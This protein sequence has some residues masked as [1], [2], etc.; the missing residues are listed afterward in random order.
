M[1]RINRVFTGVLVILFIETLAVAFIY[2]TFYEAFIIGLP[3]LLVPFWLMK[4]LPNATLTKHA[5]GLAAMIF[6]ALHIHQ[7]NGLIEVHFEIF[8]LLAT[9][10]IFKDWR[11]FISAVGLIAVHH[12]SFYF[13]Q[14]DNVG[15]YLFD[16]D[17]LAFSTVILHAV[18]AIVEGVVAGFIA[19]TLYEDSEVGK[20]LARVI[21]EL[22][23]DRH[24]LNLK[25]RATPRKSH[26]LT[27]F[28][29]L[30]SVLENVILGLRSQINDFKSNA[31]NLIS[32]KSELE[33]SAH[34][35]Q[36]ETE[37][38]MCSVEEMATTITSI[39]QDTTRLK[40]QMNDANTTTQ[41]ANELMQMINNESDHLT[42][43]LS[44]TSTEI[45]AL[46]SFS[47]VIKNVLSEISSIAEQT[48]LLALNAAIEAARAGE[49]GRGFAVVADEVRALANR[50]KESTSKVEVT[51]A[52][53]VEHSHS[54][55]NA[56]DNS[57]NAVQSVINNAAQV[58]TLLQQA[59]HVVVD[60]SD[61]ANSVA[62]AIEEQSIVTTG[63]SK[64]TEELGLLGRNDA[65]K[66]KSVALEAEHIS[67]AVRSLEASI[68]NFS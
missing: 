43:V 30:L 35:R 40:D 67:D 61:I 23:Y 19:K 41:E 52:K 24:S 33:R 13:M 63:I 32:A 4:T 46:A 16:E 11:I 60:S 28:N 45:T 12:L 36:Q 10:V 59:S 31:N 8:I 49:Q 7:L 57:V 44:L 34:D 51:L 3:A 39:A 37:A 2:N 55:T 29:E 56:M 38:I 54:S 9:L 21:E 6:A 27:G 47:E 17:R 48:N 66:V 1:N 42:H 65:E 18:Y 53:M 50:T 20:E 62:S 64:N 25:L 22:T 5:S 14:V 26:V 68:A 15:V 58:S